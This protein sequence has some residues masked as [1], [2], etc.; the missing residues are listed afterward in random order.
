MIKNVYVRLAILGA[1]IAVALI[2][3][4]PTMVP[5]DPATGEAILPVWWTKVKALPQ[6]RINLGLDLRG[7]VYLVYTVKLNEAVRM[8]GRR[9]IES[10]DN[11][12][13]RNKGIVVKESLITEDNKVKITFADMKS[14]QE[15]GKPAKEEFGED[16]DIREAR[17]DPL[18]LLFQMKANSIRRYRDEALQ[19]VR[20]TITNRVDKWGLAEVSVQIKPPDQI[21][22]ELPGIEETGRVEKIINAQANLE[23]KLVLATG[24]SRESILQEKGGRISRYQEIVPRKDEKTGIIQEYLLVKNR[25]DISG[26]CIRNARR[27]FGGDLG[28]QPV[29]FFTLKPQDSCAGKFARL[30]SANI[31][32]QLAIILDGEVVSAPVIRA[33]IRDSGVIEGNFTMESANDLAIV[34]K[35]GSLKVPLVKDRVEKIGPSLGHD[36]IVRGSYA[37]VVGG[38]LVM[39]FM[40]VYYRFGGATCDLALILNLLFILSALSTFGATLTLPGLAGIVLTVGMAVDANVLVFE[41]I[42]EELRTGKTARASVELGYKRALVTIL[43]ANITTFI[44]AVVLYFNGTGPIKGF[45]VTLMFGIVFSVFTAI[46][47]TRIFIDWRLERDPD[48]ELNI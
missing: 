37:I 11:E 26:E 15:G 12:D 23:L 35:A 8:E 5:K 6:K 40:L 17:D 43:D 33:R 29:I 16:W 46:F 31:D 32:K 10:L 36:H 14:K 2:S 24:V 41:R 28:N 30:T 18:T 21:N 39:I 38:T 19:Q 48:A 44:T 13:N 47:V 25:P 34:L 22:I 7:G 42:R 9:I 27:G 45:A 1:I 20:R 4:Y 3:L